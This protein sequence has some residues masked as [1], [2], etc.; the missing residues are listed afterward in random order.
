MIDQ[1]YVDSLATQI[2]DEWG[3]SSNIHT[4]VTP[5]DVSASER[6][7]LAIQLAAK[8]RPHFPGHVVT[9]EEY[10]VGQIM[11]SKRPK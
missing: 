3:D 6:A 8:I 10:G 4:M 9:S 2:M 1:D 5:S 7:S 11:V